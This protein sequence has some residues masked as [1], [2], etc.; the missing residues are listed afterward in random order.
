[1]RECVLA[2]DEVQSCI[3]SWYLSKT[4][5]SDLSAASPPSTDTSGPQPTSFALPG[6]PSKPW[7]EAAALPAGFVAA[8]DVYFEG[9]VAEY[10]NLASGAGIETSITPSGSGSWTTFIL[11]VILHGIETANPL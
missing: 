7:W 10:R 4:A 1:M 8:I 5:A 6:V 9:I 11:M 2:D 3:A